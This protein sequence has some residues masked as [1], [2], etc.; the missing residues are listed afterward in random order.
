MP[1]STDRGGSEEGD[2]HALP[3]ELVGRTGGYDGVGG[4]SGN[5]YEG[6]V[7]VDGYQAYVAP[8]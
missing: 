7:V 5:G 8:I 2:A 6:G 1:L 3:F 4:L